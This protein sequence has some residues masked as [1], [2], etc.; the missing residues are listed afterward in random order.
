MGNVFIGSHFGMS[1][2]FMQKAIIVGASSGI[3]KALAEVLAEEGYEL[4]LASR[5]MERLHEVQKKLK[6]K[7][8]VKR[9]D[10]EDVSEA[11]RELMALI[12]EM[13]G[14]DLIIVNAGVGFNNPVFDWEKEEE[15]IQTNVLGFAA[16]AHTAMTYFL[17]QG[18]GHLVGISSV[19]GLRGEADSPSYSASKAFV[20]N[21]LEGLRGKACR[22]GRKICVTDIRPGWVDTDMA[23]GAETFWMARVEEAAKQIY[24]AIKHKRSHAYITRRWRLYAWFVKCIPSWLYSKWF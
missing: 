11:Q 21:F 24:A 8:V 10:V 5:R 18:Q 22:V 9:I 6:T 13:R 4:G 2:D 23:K 7:T 12:E 20:S 19:S 1:R 17:K 15:T 14:V 16:M 3:G